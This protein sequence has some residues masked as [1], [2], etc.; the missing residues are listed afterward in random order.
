MEVKYR[1]NQDK[2]Y[3][4]IFEDIVEF[5]ANYIMKND[6]RSAILG[7]SGGIDS[8]VVAAILY[9]TTKR[10]YEIDPEYDF[11]FFGYSL[12]TSTTNSKE[13]HIARMVGWAFC[14]Q[15]GYTTPFFSEHDITDISDKVIEDF[16]EFYGLDKFAKGNIKA[17]L[18]MMYLYNKARENKGFVVGT[19]NYTEMLLGFSTIGGDALA[20]YM[21]L[22]YLWKTDVY[23]IARYLVTKY[24]DAQDWN[25]VAAVTASID[26]PPQDGLGISNSD[27]DQIGAKNYFDVDHILYVYENF[28]AEMIYDFSDFIKSEEYNVLTQMYGD[29]VSNVIMRRRKNFKLNLPIIYKRGWQN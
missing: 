4:E 28:M 27:M 3:G 2:N 23:G 26:I 8:T 25:T 16:Q 20:D 14:S 13:H 17:R 7:I 22:Q 21:P 6:L 24:K 18:R 29:A 12:P 9:E 15:E 19:D 11:K 10:I 1:I 5:S